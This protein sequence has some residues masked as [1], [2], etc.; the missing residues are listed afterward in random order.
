VV[1]LR[2]V[3]AVDLSALKVFPFDGQNWEA[4]AQRFLQARAG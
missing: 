3:D 2:C 4:A 1:N